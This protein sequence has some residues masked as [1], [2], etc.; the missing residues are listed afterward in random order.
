M[1]WELLPG[2]MSLFDGEPE[3]GSWVTQHGRELRFDEIAEAVGRVCIREVFTQSQTWF[4]AVRIER[5]ATDAGG[6]RRV[7]W[8]EFG[9][10]R[11]M[12]DERY[13]QD[14]AGSRIRMYEP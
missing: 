7:I 5:V 2:Q 6:R 8:R 9:R 3:P 13:F 14:G 12:A 4:Q 11:G 10:R 1:A